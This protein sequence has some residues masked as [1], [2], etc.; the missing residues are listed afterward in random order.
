MILPVKGSQNHV[1]FVPGKH[2]LDPVNFRLEF[3]LQVPFVFLPP[4]GH[5]VERQAEDA[6]GR[7]YAK[8][9]YAGIPEHLLRKG[10]YKFDYLG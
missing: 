2:S 9:G 10:K 6:D 3:L 1:L 8:Y 7:A 5:R 4:F